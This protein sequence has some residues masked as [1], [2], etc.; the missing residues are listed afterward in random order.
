MDIKI[1]D[2]QPGVTSI[3][4]NVIGGVLDFYFFAGSNPLEVSREYAKI[5][6]APAEVP[7]WSF[8]LHQ[9]RFGYQNFVDVAGVITNYSAAGIP[10]ETMWTDIDYMDR[11]RV[12]TLDPDYFPLSRMREIVDHLHDNGQKYIVMVDPALGYFPNEG[13]APVDRGI[14]TDI[15]LKWPNGSVVIGVVWP[16]PSVWPDW[17]H[18]KVQDFWNG[19]FELFFNETEGLDID[20]V[21]IDMNEPASF[22]NLPCTDPWEQSRERQFPP[23][24]AFPPPDINTPIFVKATKK[25][26]R[27]I[28][29]P[30]YAISDAAP[31][32]D[33]SAT[34]SP[35]NA[36]HFNN[37]TEY[38][39]HNLYGT[40][41]STSTHLAMLNRRPELRTLVITRSTFAGAGRHVGKWLGDNL[42]TWEQ[43]RFS[44]AG[45]LGF[46]SI[47]QIPM[48]GSDI[49]GFGDNTTETLCA[50]WA[51]LGGF[52]PFMRNHN[53]DTSISQEFYR[54]P[55]VTQAAKNVLDMRYRL[56]DYIYTA[57]H[58]ASLDGTPVLQPLFYRFP[59]DTNT[60]SI[61]HQF[62]YGSS[63]LVSPVTE[64]NSTSVTIYLPPEGRYYDFLTFAPVPESRTGNVTLTN[65]DFTKIPVHIVG[66][67]V[68]PLRVE[69]AMITDELRKKD[70]EIV[71]APDKNG[72]AHGKLY[73][74]DGVSIGQSRQTFLTMEYGNGRLTITG[75]FGHP[76]NVKLKRIRILGV[77]KRP[78]GVNFGGQAN[79]NTTKEVEYDG[80]KKVLNVELGTAFESAF[81]LQL[82]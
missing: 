33:L 28:L 49:C 73:V 31:N 62:L 26:K 42:S 51:M 43:Y 24:R 22:C 59:N 5:A 57:F 13:Y 25:N 66:G 19:E 82:L 55:L 77:P 40:M 46:T 74:D 35:V 41:M 80:E 20:G 12:F 34:T 75:E 39:V 1:N 81:S 50:R 17:F 60:F 32:G 68:V 36:T 10:L 6:G 63:I 38:D 21:W 8:G 67:A 78:S 29:D 79:L 15:F 56:L 54:W 69:G 2:T 7:Y 37:L 53:Q 61:E 70:F 65:V 16:G 71:I 76:L 30:P 47:Y 4:Y 11:R 52:Y 23:P 18:P 45:M 9:C 44:I 64:E 72:V 27:S 48:V 3:E 14:E 58:T